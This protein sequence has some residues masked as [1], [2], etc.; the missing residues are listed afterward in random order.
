M[1]KS[2]QI[3]VELSEKRERLNALLGE[4]TLTDEQ[5]AELERLTGEAQGLEKR[6]RAALTAEAAADEEAE[7]R[8]QDGSRPEDRELRGLV[9]A[10]SLA[11]IV[12]AAVT[13]SQTDGQTAELQRHLGI[14]AA[15][16]PLEL[17]RETRA[18]TPVTTATGATEAEVVQP[19]FADGDLDWLRVGRETVESGQ[20]VFP[21]LTTRPSVSA[22]VVNSTAAPETT[23]AFTA[24]A[25]EPERTQCS[26]FFRRS[27]AVKFRGMEQSLRA[28]LSSALSEDLDRLFQAE[29]VKAAAGGGL[30]PAVDI[31]AGVADFAA[32]KTLGAGQVDGRYAAMKTDIRLLTGAAAYSHADTAY[33]STGDTSALAALM[34]ETGGV[35]VSPHVAAAANSKQD[36]FVRKGGRR[37][38][39]TAVWQG[40]QLVYDEVTRAPQGEIAITAFMLSARA[41]LRADGFARMAAQLK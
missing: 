23:G 9:E 20:A 39:V 33:Q 16:V 17:L 25:L 12:S 8:L 26:F 11:D 7:R 10:A 34:A 15:D 3:Q 18:V 37:D 28:A 30:G 38:A 32:Y 5:T 1:R 21:V 41:V 22:P 19:V 35:R 31:K 14:G 29:L 24:A 13:R 4:E 27:D 40:V 36:I 6:F 2:V